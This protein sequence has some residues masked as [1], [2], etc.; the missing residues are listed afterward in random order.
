MRALLTPDVMARFANLQG[1][2]LGFK[3]D[4]QYSAE[5]LQ[6]PVLE[7]TLKG[8]RCVGNEMNVIGG[9]FYAAKDGLERLIN[10]YPGLYDLDVTPGIPKRNAKTP[11]VATVDVVATYTLHGEQCEHRWEKERAIV[12]RMNKGMLGTAA[13]G[14]AVRQAYLRIWKKLGFKAEGMGEDDEQ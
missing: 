14:K 9:N 4:R 8:F 10:Q 12:V 1:T 2:S 5:E 6:V 11:D 7:A 3:T 13:A